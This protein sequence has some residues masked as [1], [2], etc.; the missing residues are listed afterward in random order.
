[1]TLTFNYPVAVEYEAYLRPKIKIEFG[2][3]DQQP[4]QRH[5]IKPYVAEEFPDVFFAPD[6][7]VAVLD[8]ERTFWEKVTLLHAENHRPD[9]GKLKP[10]IS[11]HWSDVAAMSGDGRFTDEKLSLDLLRQVI[12]FKKTYFAA[13]W[14][15]YETAMP[16]TLKIVPN[17]A[18]EKVLRD[19]Y[20][21]MSEMFWDTRFPSISFSCS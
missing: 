17:E 6:V 18:L 12:E 15:H 9:P 16:G 13:G 21:Q 11:R 2:R 4:S 10:R 14:A 8:C 7:E 3:G 5:R 1:M 20:K 19:D